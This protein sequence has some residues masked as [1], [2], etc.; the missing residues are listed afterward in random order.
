MLEIYVDT[1]DGDHVRSARVELTYNGES[2]LAN[3]NNKGIAVFYGVPTGTEISYTITA[4]GYN[5]ATGKWIIP[6]EMLNDT[7]VTDYFD[8]RN[9]QTVDIQ[10]IDQ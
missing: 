6:T 10:L 7:T 8:R 2:N 3:T 1:P 4:A 5:A 9:G